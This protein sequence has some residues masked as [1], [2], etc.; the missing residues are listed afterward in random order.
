MSRLLHGQVAQ[1][2]SSQRSR[3]DY[4]FPDLQSKPEALLPES[5]GTVKHLKALAEAL[6]ETNDTPERDSAIPAI[7][8]Y[9]GQFLDHE[10]TFDR[11]SRTFGRLNDPNFAPAPLATIRQLM[12]N[13]R[14]PRLDLDCVYGPMLDGTP[15]PRVGDLMALGTVSA[16]EDR[17]P[18]KDE[19]NDLPRKASSANPAIDR[20]ALIGDPRNDENLIVA[21]LH[22]A[23]LR[24]HNAIIKRGHSFDEART[25]LR[26]HFQWLVIHDFLMRLANPEIVGQILERGHAS[27]YEPSADDLFMP[28]EFSVGAYRFGHSMV[29]KEYHINRNFTK[30]PLTQLFALTASSGNLNPVMGR[31]F[32]TLPD[33][34]IIEWDE[35]LDGGQNRARRIDTHLVDPLFELKQADGSPLADQPSLAARN[36][37]RGYQLRIPTGQAVANYLGL[38]VMTPSEIERSVGDAQ[39]RLL[40][41]SDLFTRTPLWYYILAEHAAIDRHFPD[42]LGP[43]GSTI[44]AEV[45]IELIRQS[46]DSILSQDG[47]EPTLGK[48]DG[49]FMLRDFL[50][51]AGVLTTNNPPATISTSSSKPE[52][53]RSSSKPNAKR[54]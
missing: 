42:H 26:Q 48:R 28:L 18:G 1:N 25:L 30:E 2:S 45:L 34:W 49:I 12:V 4:L 16:T 10:I 52:A 6:I 5:P 50:A 9:F 22:V 33:N 14:S 7:Y 15:I 31:D 17:I 20:E 19:F 46:A 24:A 35:F 13:D 54:S 38:P 40:R 53:S 32:P 41:E 21:Q 43:V 44:V 11:V 47:W 3:F 37:L 23:F 36:L 27:F 39:A 8:T 51:L 29:R